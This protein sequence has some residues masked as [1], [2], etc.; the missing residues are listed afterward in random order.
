[1][2]RSGLFF[3][4]WV[5]THCVSAQIQFGVKAG[6]NLSDVVI[7]NSFDPNVEPAF[8]VKPGL[9]AGFFVSTQRDEKFGFAA[10][11]LYSS[12]GVRTFS[13]INL[14]YITV[15]LLLQYHFHPKF[16]AEV[17]PEIGYLVSAHSKY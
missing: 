3:F 14:H 16:F 13:V 4:L 6:L 17:G 12:K 5:A 1:M 8:Q 2:K 9:H 7:N 11:L 15:P 10:E